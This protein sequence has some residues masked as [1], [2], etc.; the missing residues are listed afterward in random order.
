M[1]FDFCI[2]NPPYQDETLGENDNY[3]PQIYNVFIDEAYK[4]ANAVELIHP[5]RFLFNAGSTPK[6]WNSKMLNDKHFHVLQYESDARTF[7]PN[8][9]ITGGIAIS[10][11]DHNKE[12]TPIEVY[13]SFP[14]VNTIRR[15]VVEKKG[16]SSFSE[17]VKS[18]YSYH[19]SEELYKQHPE[20]KG[21]LSDGHDFDLKSNVFEKMPSIFSDTKTEPNMLLIYGRQ[22]NER[23]TKYI[24]AEYIISPDNIDYYKVFIAGADGAAGT[25][26]KP[27][28][29]RICGLP[30]IGEKRVGS[31]ESFLSIGR[32][33]TKSEAEYALSYI[34][35]KFSR[36]MLG[37]LK[38][39]QAVTPDKWKYVPLQDF[40]SSS[41]IDWTK[42]ISEIDKQLYKKYR[43]SAEEINFIETHVK[44]MA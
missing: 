12:F 1:K 5:G 37:I 24:K 30:T 16:F 4:I 26:G 15:K 40:T 20:L 7:F 41:D 11:H 32:F 14:E 31:T 29:A 22:N 43:L 38:A 10:Y 44:E 42:S 28:P 18:A 9:S 19:F 27:V 25:I 34:K 21:V 8:T 39:T 35:S 36:F 6:A 17:I 23:T 33:S 2:G 3:A 13:S